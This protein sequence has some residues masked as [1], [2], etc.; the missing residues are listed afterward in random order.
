MDSLNINYHDVILS[1]HA[2]YVA[3]ICQS[4]AALCRIDPQI[5][6]LGIPVISSFN[7]SLNACSLLS[8]LPKSLSF[9]Y[10]ATI[11]ASSVDYSTNQSTS[12]QTKIYDLQRNHARDSL[13]DSFND[14]RSNCLVS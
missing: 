13:V 5:F 14:L 9:N 7:N 1:G 4:S 8:G 10:I 11:N 12:L 3:A 6:E 2:A